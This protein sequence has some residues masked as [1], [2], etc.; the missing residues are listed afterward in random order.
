MK[1]SYCITVY[2]ESE[3]IKKLLNHLYQNIREEDEIVVLWDTNGPE[4]IFNFLEEQL[5][6]I[7]LVNAKFN[8]HFADWKNSFFE[9]ASGDFF[10]QIDADEIPNRFLIKNLP[11]ILNSNPDNEVY[12]VPRENY[13]KG[14]TQEHLD[15][16]GWKL[17]E[18]GRNCWPDYQWRIYKNSPDIRWKNKVHEV[19]EGFK[20]YAPLPS[21]E[22][23][24]LLHYKEISRQEK[25]N[26]YYNSL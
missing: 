6:N 22:Q 15:K 18:K 11:Q 24:S 8:K 23:F 12:L 16:W 14:I 4:E 1:I 20:T 5:P 19:L 9:L 25:Q 26:N 3:E 7:K 10:F 13:V 2:N 21:E 17:D